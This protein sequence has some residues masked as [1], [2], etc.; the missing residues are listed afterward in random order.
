MGKS[1]LSK[2]EKKEIMGEGVTLS[3]EEWTKAVLRAEDN[4]KSDYKDKDEN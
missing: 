3:K 4:Y 2:K 1:A